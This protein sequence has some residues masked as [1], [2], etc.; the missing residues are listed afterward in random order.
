[1][2]KI[3]MVDL[4]SQY[5]KIKNDVDNAVLN[6]MDSA[7]FINGPEVKSF[8]NELETYLDVKHV[9]PCANG[10]DALQIALMALDLQEGDEVVTADFT[11]A[12]TVEVIHL[13]KLKSVLVDVDYD[14]FTIST[15]QIRKAITPKTKAIIPVH[16]F[17]QCA[18]MEEILKIAEEHNLFVIEDDAQAIGS[19][20]TFSDGTV[21]HAGTMSTVGTTSFFPSKNLGCYGDGGAIFTNNDDLAYKI[22]GI[23]NHGMYER[24]YHDE[25]G[26]NSRLDSIQAAILRKKLPN[27]DS[28]NDARRKAADY[29]DE[30][31]AGNENILTPKRAEY[32]THVFHQY[33]LRILNGKRNELQKFL[34]EKEIPAMIYY[35]VALRKQKAYFQE[36]NDADFVNTDKL[37]DQVIS[38]PMHTELDEEQLKYITDAVLEFMG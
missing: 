28:Y 37:L 25:V 16:I 26:V 7:A 6:V 38:L 9:I 10:T 13:L 18:N 35:P 24:Y 1:M 20:F 23:V 15:E 34:T 3:Q 8:Q 11:F 19:Q 36:S 5:Y 12:A 21:R 31:F 33:T 17:G 29:Y 27:L 30:A 2:K 32:S 14:T 22:R 4:Q